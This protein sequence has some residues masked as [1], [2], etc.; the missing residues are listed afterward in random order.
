MGTPMQVRSKGKWVDMSAVIL[1]ISDHPLKRGVFEVETNYDPSVD[2]ILS[3]KLK[4]GVEAHFRILFPG[5]VSEYEAFVAKA[6]VDVR[7]G[8][9]WKGQYTLHLCSEMRHHKPWRL[10][11]EEW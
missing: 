1:A 7:I 3:K 2:R 11:F 9:M 4:S 10:G 8:A 6:A 5:V